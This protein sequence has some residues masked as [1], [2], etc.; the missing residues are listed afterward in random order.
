MQQLFDKDSEGI[1]GCFTRSEKSYLVKDLIELSNNLPVFDLP[2]QGIDIG[3]MPWV[4]ENVKDFCHHYKRVTETD[5]KYPVIL[6]STG[7]I[8]DGWYRVAKA[9]LNGDNSIKAVRLIVMPDPI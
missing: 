6:D 4:I 3:I 7:Y 9:I 8:C 5:M 2:L 1:N